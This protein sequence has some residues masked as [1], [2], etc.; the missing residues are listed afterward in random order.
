MGDAADVLIDGMIALVVESLDHAV[1]SPRTRELRARAKT[2]E[3]AL[4][5]WS[6]SPPTDEQRTALRELVRELHR[7][8]MDHEKRHKSYRATRV[9]VNESGTHP[10]A[11]AQETATSV[12][13]AV[14]TR[15]PVRSRNG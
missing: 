7:D 11:G 14:T 1:P 8:A 9:G 6:A 5:R 4:E 12:H 3:R 10:M 15:L 2:F 13:D